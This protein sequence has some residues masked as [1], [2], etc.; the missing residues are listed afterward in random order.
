MAGTGYHPEGHQWESYGGSI[1]GMTH[2]CTNCAQVTADP[3]G[4]N[5]DCIDDC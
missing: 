5:G 1:A 4:N 2:I 3:R